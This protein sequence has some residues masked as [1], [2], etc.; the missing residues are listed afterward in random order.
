M[1][2][3]TRA[4]DFTIAWQSVWIWLGVWLGNRYRVSIERWRGPARCRDEGVRITV[5]R[6]PV[7]T[8]GSLSPHWDLRGD[9]DRPVLRALV[10][11][12]FVVTPRTTSGPRTHEGQIGLTVWA[13]GLARHLGSQAAKARIS[14]MM[15]ASCDRNM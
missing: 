9:E 2:V 15:S 13:D 12:D 10:G 6:D 8:V 11:A 14:R 3:F 4:A 7:L 1:R 5:I